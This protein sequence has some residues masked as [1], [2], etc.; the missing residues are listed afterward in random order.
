MA[1]WQHS[2]QG[3][4]NGIKG[5][6]DFNVFSGD[7]DFMKRTINTLIKNL[8]DDIANMNDCLKNED[9]D[10]VRSLAHKMKSSMKLIGVRK[11]DSDITDIEYAAGSHSKLK[12]LPP[13][14]IKMEN[15][16]KLVIEELRQKIQLNENNETN[17]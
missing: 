9:W 8:T 14:I 5:K 6:V 12:A 11:L 2:D 16:C 17:V 15:E 7:I 1:F 10:G 4:I 13:M 3:N